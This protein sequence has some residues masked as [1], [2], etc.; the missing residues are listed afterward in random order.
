M[1][2]SILSRDIGRGFPVILTREVSETPTR[3]SRWRGVPGECSSPGTSLHSFPARIG[4]VL[5]DILFFSRVQI[6]T[7]LLA[8]SAQQ[9]SVNLARNL[10]HTFDSLD[11]RFDFVPIEPGRDSDRH[12][13]QSV[14]LADGNIGGK[15]YRND[16]LRG[17][18]ICPAQEKR[19]FHPPTTRELCRP[20]AA[21]TETGSRDLA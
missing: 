15:N 21:R 5:P 7:D 19:R 17:S 16:R 14:S 12:Q 2:A 13:L 3:F 20:L 8:R 18:R 9:L 1:T 6:A 11:Q 10:A 4:E